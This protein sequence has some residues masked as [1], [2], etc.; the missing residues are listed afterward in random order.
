MTK[1]FKAPL[2]AT[3]I[4]SSSFAFAGAAADLDVFNCFEAALCDPAFAMV[5]V[6]LRAGVRCVFA[7]FVWTVARVLG[8]FF[9]AVAV[10]E[11]VLD[12]FFRD[13]LDIRLPFVAFGGSTK[14][15]LQLSSGVPDSRPRL[16]KSDDAGVWL[17][18][19]H[20]PPHC[21]LNALPGR[22]DEQQEYSRYGGNAGAG[23][24]ASCGRL[25]SRRRSIL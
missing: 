19:I 2:L 24:F 12:D 17:Q 16:G 25:R 8:A 18:G 20:A 13:F 23:S 4:I 10:P 22:N 9:S 6:D 1:S 5:P 15:V 14:A 21:S 3:A 7:D 11:G